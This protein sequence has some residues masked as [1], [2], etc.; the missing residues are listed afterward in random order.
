MSY[1]LLSFTLLLVSLPAMYLGKR[2]PVPS[3]ALMAALGLLLAFLPGVHGVLCDPAA[4]HIAF[5]ILLP[6]LLFEASWLLNRSELRHDLLLIGLLVTSGVVLTCITVAGIMRGVAGWSLSAALLLGALLSATDPVSVIA[7]LRAL[8]LKGRLPLLLEAESLFNDA[9]AAVLF[10]VLLSASVGAE[11]QMGEIA[12]VLLCKTGLGIVTGSGVAFVSRAL[13]RWTVRGSST[14]AVLQL[15]FLSYLSYMLAEQFGGSGV[16][17][18]ICCGLL[19]QGKRSGA[20]GRKAE[21]TWAGIAALANTLIFLLLGIELGRVQWAAGWRTG[22]IAIAAG[23]IARAVSV[24]LHAALL[25]TSRHRVE[26]AHQHMLV[27][28]G[29]RGALALALA[30]SLP[31]SLP[32]RDAILMATM[33]MVGFSSFVQAGT[34]KLLLE[35]L[36]LLPVANAGQSA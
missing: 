32:A 9:T 2:V 29:L 13:W 35:R 20:L 12:R 26:R 10:A 11:M 25:R 31:A 28:G 22:L 5:A 4:G 17:S 24:Y 30:A 15:L 23:L 8:K 1:L 3:C 14:A 16:L 19:M 34:V 27:W 36:H 21:R 18:V 33:A 7:T 6:P